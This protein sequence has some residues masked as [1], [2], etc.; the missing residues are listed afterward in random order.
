[1]LKF[2]GCKICFI[3]EITEGIDHLKACPP[4]DRYRGRGPSEL[5]NLGGAERT[6]ARVLKMVYTFSK[7]C[8]TSSKYKRTGQNWSVPFKVLRFG[9]ELMPLRVFQQEPLLLQLLRPLQLPL[10]LLQPLLL[11]APRLFS[12]Q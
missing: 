11:P 8:D 1:M 7:G 2:N 6:C 3:D 5:A 12:L 4:P 10:L 9:L